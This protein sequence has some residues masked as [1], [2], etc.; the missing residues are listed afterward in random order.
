MTGWVTDNEISQD[1]MAALA[2]RGHEIKNIR[3]F[4]AMFD[5]HNIFYGI[6]R[7]TG[8]AMKVCEYAGTG[9]TYMDNGYFSAEYIDKNGLKKM[10]G[11]LRI[12]R[13]DMIEQFTGYTIKT[14]VKEGNVFLVLPPSPYTA[15]FYDTIPEDWLIK[16]YAILSAKGYD[17]KIRGKTTKEET[18]EEA[19]NTPGLCGVLA[20]NSMAIMSAL[21]RFI[22]VYDTHGIFRNAAVI[23]SPDFLPYVMYDFDEVKKFY[24]SRQFTLQEIAEGKSTL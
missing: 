8:S 6:L 17:F 20:F 22:P 15:N 9:Y 7:G 13:D 21:E 18:L 14:P 23:E 1:V 2:T 10:D 19:L 4:N 12:V 11:K 3:N 5:Q 24:E 16:W